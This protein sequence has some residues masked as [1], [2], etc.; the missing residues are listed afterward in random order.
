MLDDCSKGSVSIVG[1]GPG[2]LAA[3]L[4]LA[5]EG[6]Q[7]T[8]FD[9]SDAVGGR[10]RTVTAPGGYRFDIGPTF[11]L[12]PR[13]LA[14]I[15]A[16]CGER[17]EDWIKLQRLDPQYHLVFEG[18]GEIRATS[19]IA[20]LKAE[21]ARIAP[22][23]SRQVDRFLTDN[24][25]KLERFR[26][27]LEQDFSSLSSMASPTLLRALPSLRPFSTV[28]RDL[29]RYFADPRVRLAFSFQTKYLGMSPFQCP[30]LFTILSF[31]EYEHGVYHPVGGCG[32]V[33]DAMATLARR[34]GVEI[35]L[36]TAVDRVVYRNGRAVGVEAGGKHVSADAV[37]VN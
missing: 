37:V 2:G 9:K 22:A 1:A 36:S 11:F 5:R 6:L 3:A 16:T 18:G 12:Y 24:R 19:D 34:M 17:L 30:S 4:L 20:K 32:A 35:R 8:V 31:L 14:D 25:G 33:S 23:D 29:R 13:I 10:T 15:F 27:V 26:P 7:V 21:I 28:D